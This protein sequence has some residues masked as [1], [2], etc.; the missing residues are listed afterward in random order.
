MPPLSNVI[1]VIDIRACHTLSII[2][3]IKQLNAWAFL[4]S[5][6]TASTSPVFAF[7]ALALE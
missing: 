2:C 7:S 6:L 3:A 1:V 5:R 4:L